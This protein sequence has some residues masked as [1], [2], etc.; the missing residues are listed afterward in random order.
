MTGIAPSGFVGATIAMV[1]RTIAL[2]KPR[3]A[4]DLVLMGCFEK[5]S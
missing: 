5:K 3:Q 2:G 1:G 4:V